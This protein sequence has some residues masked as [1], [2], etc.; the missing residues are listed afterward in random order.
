MRRTETFTV[1]LYIDTDQPTVLEGKV[2]HVRSGDVCFFK[3][4][5]SLRACFTQ[6]IASIQ[7]R[8]EKDVLSG[9]LKAK[10]KKPA[11]LKPRK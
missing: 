1:K 2:Q 10:P 8:G 5:E 9:S 3:D 6:G 7:G 4:I 11:V